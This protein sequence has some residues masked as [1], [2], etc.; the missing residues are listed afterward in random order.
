MLLST[1]QHRGVDSG[2]DDVMPG[3][4]KTEV[5]PVRRAVRAF[6]LIVALLVV[7]A[8]VGLALVASSTTG[9]LQLTVGIALL[10]LAALTATL[11]RI[12]SA[13]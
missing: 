4:P 2:Q 5:R 1:S 8:T 13:G 6:A 7:L 11:Q 10:S 3:T 12:T 9:S